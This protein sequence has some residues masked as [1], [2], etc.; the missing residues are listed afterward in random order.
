[1]V[2]A[3]FRLEDGV[4]GAVGGLAA[5]PEAVRQRPE[6]AGVAPVVAR[7][8]A[9]AIVAI[10][11]LFRGEILRADGEVCGVVAVPCT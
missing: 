7:Q 3:G 2:L 6:R 4:E 9:L 1:M 11:A 5:R 10:A 8:P